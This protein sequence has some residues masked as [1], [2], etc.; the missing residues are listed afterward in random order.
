[1][2]GANTRGPTEDQHRWASHFTG[3]DTR[4]VPRGG[5]SAQPTGGAPPRLNVADLLRVPTPPMPTEAEMLAQRVQAS[6]RPNPALDRRRPAAAPD[7]SAEGTRPPAS[8]SPL[9]VD[10]PFDG[11]KVDIDGPGGSTVSV[12]SN[13]TDTIGVNV[14]IPIGR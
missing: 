4:P 3:V 8:P 7:A 5:T 2:S 13:L 14:S 11:A 9:Q 12:S 10:D 6:L 1:M